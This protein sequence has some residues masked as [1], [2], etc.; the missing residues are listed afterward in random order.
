MVLPSVALVASYDV[1]IYGGSSAAVTAAIAASQ[2]GT[3]PVALVEPHSAAGGM[4]SVGGLG[5]NDA[6]DYS[7]A[8]FLFSGL[9]NEWLARVSASY[10]TTERVWLPDMHVA[11]QAIDGMLADRPSIS[12]FTGCTLTAASSHSGTIMSITAACANNASQVFTG[13]VFIDASV[14][15]DIIVAAGVSYAWGREGRD[16]YNES[17]AGAMHYGDGE[18]GSVFP[19]NVSA[20]YANGTLLPWVMPGAVPPAG[21]ADDG[22]MAFQH[23]ACVT[24]DPDRTVF[25]APPGYTRDDFALLLRLLAT[26]SLGPSPPLSRFMSLIPYSSVV[27]AHGRHKYMICCGGTPFDSDAVTANLGFLGPDALA[28]GRRAALDAL[29]TRYL[30]GMLFFLATDAAV[31][32]ATRADVGRYGLCS[33]EWQDAAPVA[34]WPPALY[35][36]EGLRLVND[37]VLTQSTLVNPRL[38][39]DGVAVGA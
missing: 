23:R 9:T 20:V 5:L 21:A 38:K 25:P 19:Q 11:Q 35:V 15:G 8:S 32:N 17:L 31:P 10:N 37:A 6:L 27:A 29:H 16:A 22:I 14:T 28:P 33:D 7:Y 2:N 13:R 12:V 39:P 24:T 3:R 4:V 30:L 18:D 1:V 34:H 26:G 36:R